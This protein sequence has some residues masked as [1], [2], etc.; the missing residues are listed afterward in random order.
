VKPQPLDIQLNGVRLHGLRLDNGKPRLLMLHGLSQGALTFAPVFERL[1]QHWSITALDMR[2]HGKSSHTPEYSVALMAS[3][4]ATFL[5][6]DHDDGPV[7]L[8]GHSI[9]A[10]VAAQVA[11]EHPER[12]RQLILS[13]PPILFRDMDRARKSLITRYFVW[14]VKRLGEGTPKTRLLLSI[15]AMYPL[16]SDC[17]QQQI[18][19]HLLQMDP[20]LM[21]CL[22]RAGMIDW[23]LAEQSFRHLR[24]PTLLLQADAGILA[25]CEAADSDL[26]RTWVAGLRV[27][28]FPG[29]GHDLHLYAPEALTEAIQTFAFD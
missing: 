15:R 8:Y 11:A 18:V 9:G 16:Y 7:S 28:F 22:F 13:D 2:G 21:T 20:A 23:H 5:Q 1:A 19:D 12:V 10:M 25:A 6:T 17:V 29:A 14:A 27:Q 24:C 3:D 26:L 4:V